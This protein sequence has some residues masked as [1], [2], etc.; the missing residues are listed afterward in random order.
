MEKNEFDI[1]LKE[2]EGYKMDLK[3]INTGGTR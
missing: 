1:I 2:G 3:R